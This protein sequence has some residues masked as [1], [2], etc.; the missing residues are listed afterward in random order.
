MTDCTSPTK[1]KRRTYA[2]GRGVPAGPVRS[3]LRRKV[4][5]GATLL[6]LAEQSGVCEKTIMSVLHAERPTV[7]RGTAAL[8]LAVTGTPPVPHRRVDPASTIAQVREMV[9]NHW[10][11]TDIARAS[12]LSPR[13]LLERNMATGVSAETAAG[14]DRAWRLL[15]DRDGP[16]PRPYPWLTDRIQGRTLAE[17][18][19]GA[20]VCRSTVTRIRAGQ[21]ISRE[22]AR[23]VSTWLAG[24]ELAEREKA[25]RALGAHSGRRAA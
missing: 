9:G 21:P 24:L 10:S 20:G 2:P 19:D 4:R 14:V 6:W 23:R 25:V 17:V 15:K 13:T 18:V 22:T 3:H 12:R 16:A 11:L 7:Y 5:E 8:L 1:P